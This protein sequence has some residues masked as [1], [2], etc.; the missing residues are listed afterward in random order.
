MATLTLELPP[1]K[2]QTAVNLRRWAEVLADAELARFEGRVETDRYG[3]V[4]R[5][6][7][8]APTHGSFQARI[9]ALLDRYLPNGRVL[10][11]CPISTADGVKAADVAWASPMVI[12]ELGRR[13]CFPRA[14][15]ICVEVLSPGNTDAEIQEEMAL[16][17]DAGA[18]EVWTCA[19]SGAMKFFGARSARLMRASRVCPEFPL[20]IELR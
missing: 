17:F 10:T 16:Y 8:P 6:P 5:S 2:A 13:V 14:P 19:E 7:L 3:H 20:R 12:R 9:A 11:E 15:E 1:H 18:M 4:I